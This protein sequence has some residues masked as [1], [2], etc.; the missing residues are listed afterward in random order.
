M[1]NKKVVGF[2]KL[3]VLSTK[4]KQVKNHYFKHMVHFIL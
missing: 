1:N 2:Q 3:D 4:G